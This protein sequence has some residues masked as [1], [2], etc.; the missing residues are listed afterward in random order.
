MNKLNVRAWGIVVVIAM[1]GL[2]A[3]GQANEV[4]EGEGPVVV[5]KKKPLIVY[6]V[7]DCPQGYTWEILP[8]KDGSYLV[9]GARIECHKPDGLRVED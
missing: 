8:E 6:D 5:E 3:C 1:L 4:S 7:G 9:E 2:S